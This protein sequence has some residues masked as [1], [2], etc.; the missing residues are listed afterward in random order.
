MA[1]RRSLTDTQ[2]AALPVKAKPYN[3]PDPEQAGLY[4]RVRPTGSKMFCAVARTPNGKQVWTTIGATHVFAVAQARLKTKEIVSR[5]RQGLELSG[6]KSFE[7]VANDWYKRHVLAKGLISATDL[8]TMLDRHLIPAWR[9]REFVSVRRGD[10][11]RRL[12]QIEDSNGPV[13]ADF[14]LATIRTIC[15][16]Y[17][18]RNENYASPIVKGMRRTNAKERA[19]SRILD[20]NEI[21]AVWRTAEANGTFGAFIRL[22][23]L[24]GQ[25]R[26]KILAMKW[27]DISDGVWTIQ[28][29]AREKGTAGSLQ[30][31]TAALA[32]INMQPRYASNPYV[33]ATKGDFYIQGVSRSKSVFDK[34]AGVTNWTIYDLRRT[35]RS[36]ISRAG[37]RP[38][39]AERVLGH[40]IRG[41]E[42]VL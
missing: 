42:S 32:I 22:C 26:E 27:E 18:T 31:P 25:R 3:M 7:S 4:I 20:D 13:V 1:R 29:A 33:F 17:E 34:K 40:A 16:W 35:A 11:A 8:R 21:K 10:V 15:S 24:T 19:R 28:R 6:P 39:I 9:N 30:L 14:A 38:D 5:L 2:I 36:L 12:D 41:V 37:V 23:L